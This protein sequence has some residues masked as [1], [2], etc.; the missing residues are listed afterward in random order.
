MILPVAMPPPSYEQTLD[1]AAACGVQAAKIRISYEQELQSDVVSVGDLGGDEDA[2]VRCLA[3]AV[4]P[5]YLLDFKN[6]A[7]NA[8][9][10]TLFMERGRREARLQ[11]RRWLKERGLLRGMPLYRS[12]EIPLT[13]FVRDVESHCSVEP[14]RAIEILTPTSVTIRIPFMRSILAKGD[15]RRGDRLTCLMNVLAVS[16]LAEGGVHFG[17]VGNEAVATEDDER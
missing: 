17:F 4:H 16:D 9:Y 15:G 10:W 14:G 11:G 13:R 8:T 3:E 12:G 5:F 6:P 2:R 1:A 7:S